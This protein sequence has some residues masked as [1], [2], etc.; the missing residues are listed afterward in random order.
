VI[1]VLLGPRHLVIMDQRA[2]VLVGLIARAM[3][4]APRPP[5][6]PS[7]SS[8]CYSNAERMT[9]WPIR[10]PAYSL[11]HQVW[12]LNRLDLVE[13]NG[14]EVPEAFRRPMRGGTL[15]DRDE[16]VVADRGAPPLRLRRLDDPRR[17]IPTMK[18]G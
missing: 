3:V 15:G 2:V 17:M 14:M 12:G 7:V 13:Q 11:L 4:E 5:G 10:F 6:C 18:P 9:R 8:V 16:P 1:N